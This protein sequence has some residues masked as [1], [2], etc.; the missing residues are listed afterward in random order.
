MRL[1]LGV[2]RAGDLSLPKKIPSVSEL[3]SEIAKLE[4]D[5]Q[6]ALKVWTFVSNGQPLSARIAELR[7]RIKWRQT[8]SNPPRCL[9][10]GGFEIVELPAT[11]EFPHPATGEPVVEVSAGWA[12]TEPWYAVFSPEGER[13]AELTD[14]IEPPI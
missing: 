13:I 14:A 7:K 11:D 3:E 12:D 4:S 9:E 1:Q 10:C 2:R 6:E 5:D 8:R